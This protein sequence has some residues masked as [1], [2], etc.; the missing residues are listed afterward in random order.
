[1]MRIHVCL[2]WFVVL[3]AC[4]QKQNLESDLDSLVA[5]ERAFSRLSE[6]EGISKAFL[7]YFSVEAIAFRPTPVEAR[8]RYEENPDIPGL[9]TWRPVFAD[10]SLAG[11]LG[12]T[13]GPYEFRDKSLEQ[14]PSQY[15]HY[16]LKSTM[17]GDGKDYE[18]S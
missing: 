10:V 15:G 11:D 9:L 12:Y 6:T 3:S 2:M 14:K 16:T 5:S 17:N 7:T 1:M 4:V 18:D 13:T 8:R